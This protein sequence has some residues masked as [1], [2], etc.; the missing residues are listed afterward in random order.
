M[1]RQWY[2]EGKLLKKAN[3][4]ADFIACADYL[5]RKKYTSAGNIAIYGG[6]AGGLLIGAGNDQIDYRLSAMTQRC[7]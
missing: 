6:S 4:F 1:G 5:V 7:D 3:T 2:E